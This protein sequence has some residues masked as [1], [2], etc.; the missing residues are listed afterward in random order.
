MAKSSKRPLAILSISKLRKIGNFILRI[1]TIVLNIENSP[2]IFVTPVPP[3][4]TVKTDVDNL[5]SAEVT[6]QTRV[7]GSAAI[8]DQ[9]Y[10]IV[11]DDVHDMQGYVQSLADNAADEAAAITIIEASGFDLKNQGVRVK[12]PLAV[13]PGDTDGEVKLVAKSAGARTS[14]E[15]QKSADGTNWLHLPA[16]LQA[17]TT[18]GGFASGDKAYFRVRPIFKEG[19]GTWSASVS[20]IV[21]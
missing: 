14:Y 5:E 21:Q 11:L 2:L 18:A 4:A 10:D 15:W 17:K 16:T 12:P 19:P 6:A 8:R 3:V 7:P 1:R 20:I 9:K 13:K